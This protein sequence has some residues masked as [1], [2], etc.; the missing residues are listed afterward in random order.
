MAEILSN[1]CQ[2]G[3]I[4]Q[5]ILI[6]KDVNIY[7]ERSYITEVLHGQRMFNTLTGLWPFQ[8]TKHLAIAR[9]P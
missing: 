9:D 6:K 3:D 4:W 2:N 1:W 8:D 5:G 7:F